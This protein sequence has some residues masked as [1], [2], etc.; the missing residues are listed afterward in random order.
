MIFSQKLQAIQLQNRSAVGLP[1]NV[2]MDK[3][4]LPM[5]RLDD[6]MFPFARSIIDATQDLVCAYLIDPAYYLSEA[7]AGMIALERVTRYIPDYIPIIFDAKFGELGISA[8]RYAVAAF[9]AFHADAVTF[10]SVPSQATIVAFLKLE[11]KTI[12]LPSDDLDAAIEICEARSNGECGI[13]IGIDQ[14]SGL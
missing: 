12:F 3:L 8:D 1:L 7:A 5:A 2:R 4:P 14:L 10:G 11:G 6:P 9:E 13:S